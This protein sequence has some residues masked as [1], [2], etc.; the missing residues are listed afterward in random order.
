MRSRTSTL[1]STVALALALMAP[2]A[3]A[4]TAPNDDP[5]PQPGSQRGLD[6]PPQTA[7]PPS[8]KGDSSHAHGDRHAQHQ[9]FLQ[10]VRAMDG[11]VDQLMSAMQSSR[12]EARVDAIAAVVSELVAQRKRMLE[13]VMQG[14]HGQGAHAAMKGGDHEGMACC[15]HG[16]HGQAKHAG[17]GEHG[18]HADGADHAEGAACCAE[19]AACCTAGAACCAAH[20]GKAVKAA[21]SCCVEGAACCSAGAACC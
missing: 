9:A 17:H 5:V 21:A 20:E 6:Q 10:E 7:N 13:M 14:M 19:G 1:I 3:F 4:Q 16:K 2:M 8:A 15:A 12:G 18:E 11:R